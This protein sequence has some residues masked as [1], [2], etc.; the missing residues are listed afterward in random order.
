LCTLTKER[1]SL[2]AAEKF[3]LPLKGGGA[4]KRLGGGH[5]MGKK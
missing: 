3:F 5:E 4:P 1:D 2:G